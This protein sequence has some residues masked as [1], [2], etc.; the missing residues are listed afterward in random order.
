MLSFGLAFGLAFGLTSQTDRLASAFPWWQVPSGLALAI[1]IAYLAYRARMLNRSGAFAAVILGMVVFGFGGLAWSVLLM[2]FFLSSSG[3]S[4]LF[5]DRKNKLDEKFS[6]GS[7]RDAG[8]VLANGGLAGLIVI[9]YRVIGL[10]LPDSGLPGL[11]WLAYIASLAAANADTW[12]TELGV[13]SPAPPVLITT[14]KPVERGTSGGIS[15]V[16]TLA[17]AGGAGLIT[18][19]AA[20]P[21][22]TP[23]VTLPIPAL[24]FFLAGTA[25]LLGSLVDSFLG[26][27]FQAV[28][29]CPTCLKDTEHHPRHICG[30]V[31]IRR[32][33]LAWL[34]NDW[35]NAVCTISAA[36]I[37]VGL[38]LAVNGIGGLGMTMILSSSAFNNGA[39][40]PPLYTCSG[41]NSSPD[42]AWSGLP[43]GTQSLALIVEDPDA[44]PGTFIHWVAYNLPPALA[45]LAA[46]Q[47]KTASLSEGNQGINSFSKIGYDGPCPPPGTPPHRYYF[48]FFALDASP[49]LPSGLNAAGLRKTMQG[50]ILG[51]AEWMGKF[52]R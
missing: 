18:L 34:N 31:T 14:L 33:G 5:K 12:A 15:V 45:G 35:V 47:P 44:P 20:L 37:S 48:R 28:F 38:A 41:D 25:G 1:L 6:K 46:G 22:M 52:T 43:G 21:G 42:L 9:A 17:G 23:A 19:V 11:C 36:V 50:H 40:I 27:T 29:F 7:Q 4:H 3:L 8:Q 2:I 16:G 32:R 13:L 10:A 24:A 49:D 30:T 26:A 51:Q 39:D